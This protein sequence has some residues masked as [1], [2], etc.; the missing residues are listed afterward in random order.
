MK[1]II[2]LLLLVVTCFCWFGCKKENSPQNEERNGNH[3]CKEILGE[4]ISVDEEDTYIKFLQNGT[5]ELKEDGILFDFEWQYDSEKQNFR[6]N[7]GGRR[8]TVKIRTEEGVTYLSGFGFR[9]RAEDR[10]KVLTVAHILR[11]NYMSRQLS[12]EPLLP[13]GK[14]LSTPNATVVFQDIYLSEDKKELLCKVSVTP[15]KDITRDELNNLLTLVKSTWFDKNY[16]FQAVT[17]GGS[18]TKIK[19]SDTDLLAGETLTIEVS[20]FNRADEI[21]V[22]LERWGKYNGYSVVKLEGTEYYI[23]FAEYIKQPAS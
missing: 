2:S 4:W 8:V 21:P 18:G 20:I 1:K 15:I 13:L 10:E 11:E 6:L 3:P 17:T 19:L 12:G 23:N 22:V 9:F 14:E 7:C 5:G 16:I